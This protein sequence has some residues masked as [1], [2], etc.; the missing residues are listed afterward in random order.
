MDTDKEAARLTF[1]TKML[2]A[3]IGT[4][5]YIRA[6]LSEKLEKLRAE[7]ALLCQLSHVQCRYILSDTVLW[8][9]PFI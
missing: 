3:Y 6:N 8:R 1:D 5:E 4:D 2:G 9:S 7:A